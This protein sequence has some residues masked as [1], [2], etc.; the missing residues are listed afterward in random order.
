MPCGRR[1]D[2]RRRQAGGGEEGEHERQP[3]PI[4]GGG[5]GGG[6]R[7]R[8]AARAVGPSFSPLG[9]QPVILTAR[10]SMNCLEPTLSA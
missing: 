9:C 7:G 10:M 8:Q 4:G 2:R 5:A 6:A 1:G 3:A